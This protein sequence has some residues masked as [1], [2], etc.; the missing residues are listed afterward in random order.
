MSKRHLSQ[1]QSKRIQHQHHK[2]IAHIHQTPIDES[3]LSPPEKGLVIAHY[4]KQLEVQGIDGEHHG[5]TWR[6][7]L[8]SNLEAL[9]TGDFVVW[10]ADETNKIG[11]VSALL[12]RQSLLTRPDP[13]QK[14]KPVAA[15]ISL[16]LIVIAP[17]P[18]P[19]ASLIDRY[20]V[21]CE[22]VGITPLLVLNKADLLTTDSADS[23]RQLLAEYRILGYDSIEVSC[24]GDL[25]ELTRYIGHHNVVFVGQSGVGKSSL[26]NALL[27]E[28][29]QKVNIISD[30]SQLGQHTTTTTRLFHL[31][32]GGCLIDS[33][34]IREFGLWHLD[35]QQI[36]H[37]FRELQP[38]LGNCRFRN[39]QHQSEPDC[40]LKTAVAEGKIMA[41]RLESL[42]RL[43][44]ESKT[45]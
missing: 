27:P 32:Q 39:C 7:Y 33:P 11:I 5:Q 28:A 43:L 23:L 36:Q 8:R 35:E 16:I 2:R 4:G 38:L 44:A 40:A 12:P 21:A 34:G 25:S 41:R 22:T 6:C 18:T 37:G 14:I 24:F 42:H 10:Q 30:N 45:S 19:S 26:I 1:Q 29:M 13:Y 20:L 15:N 3:H 31:T 9:V 17:L